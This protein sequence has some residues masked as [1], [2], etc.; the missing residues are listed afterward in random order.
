VEVAVPDE[1]FARGV[2]T[3]AMRRELPVT[4]F[5]IDYPS[6]NDVFLTLVQQMPEAMQPTEEELAV[7]A[8]A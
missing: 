1:T 3:E 7:P 2:L 6:L 5:E 8:G 4:R